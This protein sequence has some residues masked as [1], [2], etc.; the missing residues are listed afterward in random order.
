MKFSQ[1]PLPGTLVIEPQ[2]FADDR[3]YLQ[4]TWRG[5]QYSEIGI[6]PFTQDNVSVSH[7]GVLRG[8]HTQVVEP[9]GKLVFV[10]AGT[11]F[12]TAI[13][14]RPDSPN[15]GEW[16]GAE[17]SE[18]NHRQF[19]IPQGFAHGFCVLSEQ[20]TVCY[21]CTSNYIA[22]AQRSIRWNDPDIGIDWPI[23]NPVLSQKDADAPLLR[24][25]E[26]AIPLQGS[27][28]PAR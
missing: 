21:K 15:F 4:E 13:D 19:W 17:L 14:I 2:I 1:T 3:G 6:G 20:A 25:S 12:D 24:D 8:L 9:Q 26:F 23:E 16:F 22:E 28:D 27:L 11:I 10:L 18:D 5:H 7:K